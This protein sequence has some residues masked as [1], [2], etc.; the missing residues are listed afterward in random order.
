M[1]DRAKSLER[2]QAAAASAELQREREAQEIEEA[3]KRLAEDRKRAEEEQRKSTEAQ[4][5]AEL[6]N[7]ARAAKAVIRTT[8]KDRIAF[9]DQVHLNASCHITSTLKHRQPK[10]SLPLLQVPPPQP[11]PRLPQPPPQSMISC[12]ISFTMLTSHILLAST[13][14]HHCISFYL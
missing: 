10:S 3:R 5:M 7:S 4:A 13:S 1:A 14:N 2:A 8:I 12:I 6:E 9:L 11:L